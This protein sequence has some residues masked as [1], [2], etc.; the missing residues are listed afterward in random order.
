MNFRS[1]Y[2]SL[3]IMSCVYLHHCVVVYWRCEFVSRMFMYSPSHLVASAWLPWEQHKWWHHCSSVTS[4]LDGDSFPWLTCCV[5]VSECVY[6]CEDANGGNILVTAR[7]QQH[8]LMTSMSFILCNKMNQL[9][10]RKPNNIE[11]KW[12]KAKSSEGTKRHLHE[13]HWEMWQNRIILH[14]STQMIPCQKKLQHPSLYSCP[15]TQCVCS[16]RHMWSIWHHFML[17]HHC[18]FSNTTQS[19]LWDVQFSKFICR[20]DFDLH[21]A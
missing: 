1:H 19:H 7:R 3:W 20:W 11:N 5:S 18:I 9:C 14:N 12:K 4:L 16:E 13:H 6:M 2:M 10:S 8:S 15:T 21:V 17:L